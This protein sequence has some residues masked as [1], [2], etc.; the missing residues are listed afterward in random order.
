MTTM[1][2]ERCLTGNWPTGMQGNI[3]RFTWKLADVPAAETTGLSQVN[4]KAIQGQLIVKTLDLGR[5]PVNGLLRKEVWK[6]HS[7]WPELHV[8]EIPL[9]H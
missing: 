1:N 6:V 4:P 2:F 5:P 9:S 8:T 7:S 3:R